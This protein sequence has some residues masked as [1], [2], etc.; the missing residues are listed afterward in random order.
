[1]SWCDV[2]ILLTFSTV[3]LLDGSTSLF[4]CFLLVRKPKNLVIILSQP[5]S[6]THQV[7]MC[8][9]FDIQLQQFLNSQTSHWACRLLLYGFEEVLVTRL[10]TLNLNY[11]VFRELLLE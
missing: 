8:S 3:F 6:Y 10:N 2:L 7:L 11:F 5:S 9:L 4:Y 1:M